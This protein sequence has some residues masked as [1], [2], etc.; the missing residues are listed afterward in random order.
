MMF[1]PWV[2]LGVAIAWA[3]S[4]AASAKLGYEHSEGQHA[5]A[6][7]ERAALLKE[8]KAAN[9]AFADK[10]GLDVGV[11]ISQIKINHRTIVNEVRHEREVHHKV[12]DNPDCRLPDSTQRVLN[13]ARSG[14]GRVD[15]GTSAGKP[16]PAVP[17]AAPTP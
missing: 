17:A 11:A 7:V 4:M 14:E 13:A 2:L 6:A 9:E 5:Q 16:A 8:V 10:L 12:L 3:L 1:N 15:A